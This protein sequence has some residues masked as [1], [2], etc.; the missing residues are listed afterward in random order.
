MEFGD[1]LKQE[2]KKRK[3][4]QQVVADELNVSRQTISSW[5]TE[6]SYPDIASLLR[7]SDYYQISLDTLL[8]EDVG[9]TEYLKKQEVIKS[10]KPVTL[11]L[12]LID[13]VFMAI[14]I[15]YVFNVISLDRIA[16]I[17]IFVMGMLNSI[18]LIFVAGFQDKI[19]HKPSESINNL[20]KFIKPLYWIIPSGFVLAMIFFLL[21]QFTIMGFFSGFGFTSLLVLIMFKITKAKL[22]KT[23]PQ[24][25]S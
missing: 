9:M 3:L 2:R 8:K 11:V 16:F 10:L 1:R 15:G 20:N 21:G 24:V 4:T 14:L 7:L 13:V 18:A 5:E 23:S 6:N 25:K 17:S 22:K 19:L 12:T